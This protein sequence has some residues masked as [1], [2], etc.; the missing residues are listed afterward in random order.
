MAPGALLRPPV[1]RRHEVVPL[2]V[3]AQHVRGQYAV[4]I[5]PEL[6][7]VLVLRRLPLWGRA[8]SVSLQLLRP[9][10]LIYG[11]LVPSRL[12]LELRSGCAQVA[13]VRRL[14]AGREHVGLLPA[15]GH[16]AASVSQHPPPVG[17]ALALVA[18]E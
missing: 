8:R 16:L 12:G 9:P 3:L 2:P 7:H 4:V 14:V 18:R 5:A 10:R 13:L 17:A 6:D 15:V 1:V 11:A